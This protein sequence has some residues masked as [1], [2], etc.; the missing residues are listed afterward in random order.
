MSAACEAHDIRGGGRVRS[1]E[2][3][4]RQSATT[5]AAAMTARYGASARLGGGAAAVW[6]SPAWPAEARG[7]GTEP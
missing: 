3:T 4:G 7:P 5:R 6:L 2:R 1:S